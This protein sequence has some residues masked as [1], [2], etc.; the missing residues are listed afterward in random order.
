[1]GCQLLKEHDN[2][3]GFNP[4]VPMKMSLKLQ[5]VDRR[6]INCSA[7]MNDKRKGKY[8]KKV[9]PGISMKKSCNY[10]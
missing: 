10:L 7:E 6:K 9:S 1:M 2:G 5:N 3:N 4:E 8:S